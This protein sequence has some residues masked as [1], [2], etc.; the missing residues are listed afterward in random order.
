MTQFTTWGAVMDSAPFA[1]MQQLDNWGRNQINVE[2][3][4]DGYGTTG[5][6][7]WYRFAARPNH[8]NDQIVGQAKIPLPNG[9]KHV[10]AEFD[11]AFSANWTN[12]NANCASPAPD[13]KFFLAWFAETVSCGHGRAEVKMGTTGSSVHASGAGFPACDDVPVN[14]GGLLNGVPTYPPKTVRNP[15]ARQFFD[16]QP[17]HFRVYFGNEGD[18]QWSVYVEIDGVVTHNY[19]TSTISQELTF[20]YL[21]LGSNRNLGATED[22]YLHWRSM[23][24]WA[25]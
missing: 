17:H 7:M 4:P 20:D 13:Y 18:G 1:N 11:V 9:T 10:W 8:C 15:I 5:Q 12:V 14:P 6:G 23:R 25:D 19:V 16:G 21:M 3:S 2:V 24:V 22:M